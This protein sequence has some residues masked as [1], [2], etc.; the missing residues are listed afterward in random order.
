MAVLIG[1]VVAAFVLAT[2]AVSYTAYRLASPALGVVVTTVVYFAVIPAVAGAGAYASLGL[3]RFTQPDRSN[4]HSVINGHVINRWDIGLAM[5]LAVLAMWLGLAV[6]GSVNGV[7]LGVVGELDFAP[8]YVGPV[9]VAGTPPADELA[10]AVFAVF[11]GARRLAFEARGYLF[12]TNRY[13]KETLAVTAMP[14][15]RPGSNVTAFFVCV[16]HNTGPVD[17]GCRTF[18]A[19]RYGEPALLNDASN[20][21]AV[22]VRSSAFRDSCKKAAADA[23]ANRLAPA[24]LTLSVPLDDVVFFEWADLNKTRRHA[25]LIVVLCSIFLPLLS[26]VWIALLCRAAGKH[27][28]LQTPASVAA[29]R[30]QRG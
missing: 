11:D 23:V 10:R 6:A 20:A 21:Q 25:M 5:G 3:F 28:C 16:C 30:A 24:N 27:R 8:R 1:V 2:P 12:S 15:L 22:R 13:G 4:W 9:P 14:L 18:P 19:I 7:Y 17:Y 29:E 26:A